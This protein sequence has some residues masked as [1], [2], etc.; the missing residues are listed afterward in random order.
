MKTLKNNNKITQRIRT[1]DENRKRV[2]PI[3]QSLLFLA[4][5]NIALC[6]HRSIWSSDGNVFDILIVGNEGNY[7]ELLKF[8]IDSGYIELKIHFKMSNSNAT[9][10]SKTSQNEI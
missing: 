6:G 2:R 7:R 4:R 1:V 5:Q 10:I 3:I 8:R 9:Y